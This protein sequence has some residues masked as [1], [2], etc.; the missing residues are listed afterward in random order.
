MECAHGAAAKVWAKLHP[1]FHWRHMRRTIDAYCRSCDV[2]Q[3]VK[4]DNFRK[5]GTL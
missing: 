3:K 5:Y 1:K 4:F 2:C